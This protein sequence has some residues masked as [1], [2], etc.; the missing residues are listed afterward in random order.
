MQ[1]DYDELYTLLNLLIPGSLGPSL[2]SFNRAIAA[3][4]K[5]GMAA[6]RTSDAMVFEYDQAIQRLRQLLPRYLLRRTKS[7]IA[8]QLPKKTDQIAFCEMSELQLAAYRRLLDSPDVQLMLNADK[9]CPCG[10]E[11][12][13][14]GCQ[15]EDCP[16]F[17]KVDKDEVRLLL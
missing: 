16:G 7:I 9:P 15:S 14:K 13:A 2:E 5:Q 1:N 6:D 4:L 17:W 10:S 12:T 3:P 11:K 8:H